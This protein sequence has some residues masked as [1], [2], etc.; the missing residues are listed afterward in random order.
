LVAW[1][2]SNDGVS[3]ASLDN[4]KWVGQSGRL[5]IGSSDRPAL[6]STGNNSTLIMMAWKG[7]GGDGGIYYG[8]MINPQVGI[9]TGT[10]AVMIR[11]ANRR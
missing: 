1:T 6:I 3:Y 2:S 9:P 11:G 8:S 7:A 5:G 10:G 4:G